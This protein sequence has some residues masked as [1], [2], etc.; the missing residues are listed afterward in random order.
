LA[1]LT[2]TDSVADALPDA[3]D[4]LAQNTLD[5]ALHGSAT[6]P[7]MAIETFWEAGAVP[8]TVYVK[9]SACGVTASVAVDAATVSAT[10]TDGGLPDA[11]GAVI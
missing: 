1:A 6:E 9:L 10:T 8:F 4:T 5:T 2:D 7:P 3:G 11:P